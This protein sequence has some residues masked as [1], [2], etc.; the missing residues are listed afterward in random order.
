MGLCQQNEVCSIEENTQL[1]LTKI[2]T[3]SRVHLLDF[4]RF[5]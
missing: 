2:S 4:E 5:D 3:K 1:G